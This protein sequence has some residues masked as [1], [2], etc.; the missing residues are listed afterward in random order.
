MKTCPFCGEL[1]CPEHRGPVLF[2]PMV[3]VY[4]FQCVNC[5]VAEVV[6]ILKGEIAEVEVSQGIDWGTEAPVVKYTYYTDLKAFK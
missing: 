3:E 1:T 2:R 5:L 4:H 6:S